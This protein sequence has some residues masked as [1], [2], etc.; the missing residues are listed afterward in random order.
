VLPDVQ[1]AGAVADVDLRASA[2]GEP[3]HEITL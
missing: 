2:D 1:A 3:A